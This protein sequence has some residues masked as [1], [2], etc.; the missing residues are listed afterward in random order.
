MTEAITLVKDQSLKG[1]FRLKFSVAILCPP[2]K[3]SVRGM[4]Y[5]FPYIVPLR[6][7]SFPFRDRG[8]DQGKGPQPLPV[9]W[10][11]EQGGLWPC[12]LTKPS[13]PDTLTTH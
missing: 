1:P 4:F 11:R 7:S 6:K 10:P 2:C 9:P 5:P 3:I 12:A 13:L 8:V